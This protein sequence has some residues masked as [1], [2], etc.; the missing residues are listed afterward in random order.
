MNS[1]QQLISQSTKILNSKLLPP[2]TLYRQILRIH[3]QLP[4]P[5]RLVGDDYVKSEF[6]QHKDITNPIHIVGFLT[7][8]QNYLKVLESQ[9]SNK[10]HDQED[11]NTNDINIISGS[12]SSK[13]D[14]D[15]DDNVNNIKYGKKFDDLEKFNDQQIGQLYELMKETKGALFK[16]LEKKKR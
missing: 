8:W 4:T 10:K 15:G 5:L 13:S 2:L 11:S 7:Q 9:I 12:K 1:R 6:R 3:Q 14:S 16:E